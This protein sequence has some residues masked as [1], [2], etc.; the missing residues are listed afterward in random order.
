MVK[1]VTFDPEKWQLVPRIPTPD[2][3][4]AI[5]SKRWP[6]DWNVGKQKQR[7]WGMA[8]VAP[9]CNTEIAVGQYL[10]ML[11]SAPAPKQ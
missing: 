2:M 10:R 7:E 3:L 6:D 8:V 4:E 5:R 11:K 1:T 9:E